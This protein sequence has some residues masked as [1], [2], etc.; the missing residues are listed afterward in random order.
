MPQDNLSIKGK[1]SKMLNVDFHST[2]DDIWLQN[3]NTLSRLIGYL[4]ILLPFLLWGFL[5]VINGHLNV[6]PSISH[7]YFTRSN[8][9]FISVVSLIAIF[10][11]VYK[12]SK[13]GFVCSTLAAIGALLLLLFPT[14]AFVDSCCKIC[15]S[16]SI[17]Y[18]DD[19]PY[20]NTF[21][22]VSAALFLGSL[23]VMSLYVFPKD[24]IVRIK[25]ESLLKDEALKTC[26]PDK[27]KKQNSVYI[28]CGIV[29]VVA[30]L[31]IVGGSSID[32]VFDGYYT[33]NNLTFWM[34]AIAVEAFGISWLVR[35]ERIFKS[36]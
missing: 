24:N 15:N 10:L 25:K 32:V 11:L 7:Y 20:R 2:K 6:L 29:M 9:I 36:K 26:N 23:A 19:N 33:K 30:L 5:L 14:N 34:E 16:V 12:S 3:A 22:Y 27:A 35:G 4:G 21:H 1:M 18:V 17:A 13:R 8:V 28:V 31:I